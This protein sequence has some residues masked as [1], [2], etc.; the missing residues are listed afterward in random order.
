[1]RQFL[2]YFLL[3]PIVIIFF[4]GCSEQSVEQEVKQTVEPIE[5][6]TKYSSGGFASIVIDRPVSVVFGMLTNVNTWTKINLGVT[7]SILPENVEVKKGTKFYETIASPVPGIE[8]WTNEWLV[9]EFKA[10]S[11]FVIKGRENFT[12][13]PIY[14]RL[15]YSFTK[16]TETT[17]LFKRTIEVTIDD[18]SMKEMN[19]QEVEALYRFLG[20]QWEMTA[21][22]KK[23]VEE[24]KANQ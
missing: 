12:K 7:A 14:S 21:H 23:Y 4:V 3:V 15:T 18:N 16:L 5:D 13:A 24:D 20:S 10:D 19:A 2:I 6:G 17:T 1:M 8:N 22:L 11:L 9:D